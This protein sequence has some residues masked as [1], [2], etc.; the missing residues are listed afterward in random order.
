M[1]EGLGRILKVV[2]V[3]HKIQGFYSHHFFDPFTHNQF[4]YD[5]MLM[6]FPIAREVRTFRKIHDN[7][8]EASNT[9]INHLKS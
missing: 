6:G 3:D 9:S 4:F 5:M 7:F 1:V 2:V 8:M